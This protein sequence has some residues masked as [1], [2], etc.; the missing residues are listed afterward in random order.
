VL[1]AGASERPIVFAGNDRPGVM[2]A[3]SVRSYVNRYAVTPGRQAAVFT[4]NDDGWRTAAD[5]SRCGIDVRAVID[6]RPDVAPGVTALAG[7][8]RRMLEAEVIGT[9]GG[10][11]LRSIEVRIR[12]S[13]ERLDIDLLAVSGGW[14]PNVH[15]TCHNNSRPRWDDDIAAFRPAALPHGLTVAGA[16]NGAMSLERCLAEGV[17]AGR[18]AA[19]LCGFDAPETAPSTAEDEPCAVTPLWHVGGSKGKGFIDLQNDVTADDVALARRE[20]FSSVEH[21]KRYTTLG[22]ATDQGRTANVAGIAMMAA[23]TDR[24]IAE[25]GTTAYRPPYTPVAIGALAGPHRGRH[26]RPV[27]LTPSHAWATDQGAV[28]VETGPW[29]RAQ[30][31]PRTGED[32]WLATVTREV[33]TVRAA[34]GFC[35]VS[36]LG[37]IEVQ[38]PD[39]GPFLDRLYIN[40]I[41]TLPVGRARYGV[42]LREDGFVLDDG[43]V[44]RFA[45]DRFFVTTTTANAVR[46]F[47]HMQFCHQVLWPDFDVQFV[48]AT[49]QWAQ[50]SVAGPRARDVLTVIVDP[51][52]DIS[53]AGFPYMAAAELTVCGSIPARLYRI[54]FSGELAYEVG[55][56]ARYGEALAGALMEAGAEFGIAPY[57]TEALS[58]MRIEKGHIAGNEVDGR[59]TANDLGLGRMMSRN[60]DFIGR[61]LAGRPGLT[62]PKR[63]SLVGLK[64]IDNAERLRAGA[65]LIPMVAA[66]L[67]ANDIGV[68]TS[69]AFSPSLGSW[70]GLGLLSEGRRLV[71][72][73]VQAVDP[74]RDG[75]ITVDVCAPCF[76]DPKG[77]RLRA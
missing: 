65:H 29:L 12:N 30:Y 67:A 19:R 31:F 68:V 37:K 26:F 11:S 58:A 2:L 10:K 9:R 60:K 13:T 15:L 24:T 54:S 53:N 38:G 75:N 52:F 61:I 27:R 71:G 43:T 39:A 25:S 14:Q 22:M 41:S 72:Q 20:G 56:P 45:E 48:S 17:A 7:E 36:T 50:F 42:M 3:A 40:T 59:T 18:G 33:R 66:A 44:T 28:F 55:V 70:I 64:P 47:Q 51:P 21:L 1:A 16:A 46:V 73:R 6:C 5:L 62:D 76:V 74:V 57:G 69:V 32:D 23:L 77:E 49:D 4:N 63:P 8:A 35:D 34:V